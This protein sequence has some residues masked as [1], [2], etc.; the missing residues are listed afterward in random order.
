MFLLVK[1]FCMHMVQNHLKI[2]QLYYR[3][4]VVTNAFYFQWKKEEEG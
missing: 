3:L 1:L 2:F 4:E